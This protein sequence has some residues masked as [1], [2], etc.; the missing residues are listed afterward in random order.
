[1]RR[2][3]F[4]LMPYPVL[5]EKSDSTLE[6]ND[7]VTNNGQRKN[8]QLDLPLDV[9]THY[10]QHQFVGKLSPHNL[11]GQTFTVGARYNVGEVAGQ[12]YSDDSIKNTVLR[13]NRQYKASTAEM[14][15]YRYS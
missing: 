13:P 1:M 11:D 3:P 10:N 9:I 15:E 4:Y 6:F 8:R 7:F 12:C 2:H 14:A 5:K